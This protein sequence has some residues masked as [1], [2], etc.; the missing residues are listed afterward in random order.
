MEI[1]LNSTKWSTNKNGLASRSVQHQSRRLR[2]VLDFGLPLGESNESLV[3]AMDE[4]VVKIQ[5]ELISQRFPKT[6]QNKFETDFV[7]AN[8]SVEGIANSL[9]EYYTFYGDTNRINSEIGIPFY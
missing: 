2:N 5:N 6:P 3:E 1:V 8:A 4:E 7:N 9:A